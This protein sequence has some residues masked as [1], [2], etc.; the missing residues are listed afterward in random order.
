MV[1]VQIERRGIQE[2]NVLKAMREVK[3]HLFVPD[4]YRKNAYDD[5]PLP[6][7]YG[8]T[9]SQPYIVAYMTEV[10]SPEPYFKVLEIGTGSGYQAAVLAEIVD[11]VYTIEIVK[12]LGTS[13]AKRLESLGFDNIKVK[14]G[15]GYYGWEERAP[16]DAIVV[17][18]AAE[19]VP[20]PL[21]EQLKDG[22]KMIIPV[23]SPFMTQMLSL[24]E[25]KNGKP[26]TKTLMPVRFVPFTRSK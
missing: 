14:V 25:K 15:D 26:R 17:T 10:I 8:Q 21:I 5:R 1:K 22:G 2:S 12:E 9:I 4:D 13:A 11:E 23:G 3:R 19:F 16:F 24:V 6:I 18:A 20:P 7:G